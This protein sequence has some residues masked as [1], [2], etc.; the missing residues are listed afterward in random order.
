MILFRAITHNLKAFSFLCPSLP[1]ATSVTVSDISS[2]TDYIQ[3]ISTDPQEVTPFCPFYCYCLTFSQC[4]L[5]LLSSQPPPLR[6]IV[7]RMQFLYFTLLKTQLSHPCPLTEVGQIKNA[8]TLTYTSQTPL[9]CT[10]LEDAQFHLLH[11]IPLAVNKP[12]Y[13]STFLALRGSMV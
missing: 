9:C 7:S 11:N 4:L 6:V 12:H 2:V 5:F 13:L 10:Y 8:Q 3:F 1:T